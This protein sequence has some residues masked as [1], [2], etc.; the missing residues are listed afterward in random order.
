MALSPEIVVPFHDLALAEKYFE[1]C[2]AIGEYGVAVPEEILDGEAMRRLVPALTDHVNGGFMF[3]ADR[4]TDPRTFVR[5][6]IEIL[7]GRGVE[8]LE[9]RTVLDFE[10]S[11]D[12]VTGVKLNSGR[13][14]GDE[15][16]LAAGF[17]IRRLGRKLGLNLRVIPGQ[18]YNVALPTTDALPRPV[19]VEEVHA[20]ATP[21]GDRIRLGGTMEFAGANPG[22]NQKRVD[23]I[24]RSMRPYLDLDWAAHRE[25]WAGSRPMSADGLPLIG[26]PSK[27]SNVVVAGGHGMYGYTLAPVTGRSVAELIVDGQSSIELS[28]FDPDR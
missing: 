12:R 11:G 7:R 14:G 24:L 2:V 17:G 3:P 4:A 20:V 6:L 27:Y 25:T 18:G 13:V 16:V 22:F 9:Q 26:R 10:T 8:M 15:V 23:A 21:L 5:S 19:I 1:D 28:A